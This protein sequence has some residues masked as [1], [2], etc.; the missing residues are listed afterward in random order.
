MGVTCFPSDVG[1]HS[2]VS[3]KKSSAPTVRR[4]PIICTTTMVTSDHN[5]GVK[6]VATSAKFRNDP[7]DLRKPNTGAR[8]V[9]SRSFCGKSASSKPSINATTISVQPIWVHSPN[10]TRK[11]KNYD[12]NVPASSNCAINTANITSPRSTS[13]IP[14]RPIPGLHWRIFIIP[15]TCSAWCSPFTSLLRWPRAKPR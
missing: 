14:R 4:P 3:P 5:C 12:S 8:I 9:R 1:R 6:S 10:S 11:R 13:S 7:G 2:N 15:P